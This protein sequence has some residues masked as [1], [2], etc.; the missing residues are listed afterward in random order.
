MLGLGVMGSGFVHLSCY[1]LDVFHAV[2]A[3]EGPMPGLLR[4][5]S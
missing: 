5:T 4:Q 2:L 3:V 1:R